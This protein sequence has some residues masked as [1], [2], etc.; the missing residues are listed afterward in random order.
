MLFRSSRP[1]LTGSLLILLLLLAGLVG[2][3]YV[4]LE[5]PDRFRP[6]IAQIIRSASGYEV[7]IDGRLAWRYWPPIAIDA[8]DVS[9]GVPGA[10]PFAVFEGVEMDVDLL[11]LV[12]GRG[13]LEIEQV[14]L[15]GGEILLLIDE[16]GADNWTLPETAVPAPADA[17]GGDEAGPIPIPGRLALNDIAIAYLNRQADQR[18]EVEVESLRIAPLTPDRPFDASVA[19]SFGDPA[20]RMELALESEGRLQFAGDFSAGPSALSFETLSGRLDEAEFKGRATVRF[21][22]PRALSADI[23]IDNL[24]L[25][26]YAGGRE[27]EGAE[28]GGSGQIRRYAAGREEAGETGRP[29][30]PAEVEVIPVSLLKDL[31]LDTVLR[32]D[33]LAAGGNPLTGATIEVKN[34]G[35]RLDLIA[36]ASG[37]EGKLVLKLESEL[38][39][40][41]NSRLT[42]SLD[43]LDLAQ[44]TGTQGIAGALTATSNLRL[45]GGSLGDL[46]DSLIGVTDFSVEGGALDVRPIKRMA[47]A[48]DLLRGEESP[49]S[50]WPDIMPFDRMVGQ[51]RFNRG[52][53]AGQVLNAD[54]E[55]LNIAALGGVDLQS[56]TLHYE[57]T[58]MFTQGK[59]GRFEVSNRLTGIRWP[60]TCRGGLS[61]SLADLCFGRDGAMDELVAEI[62]KQEVK[63]RGSRKLKK[64]LKKQVPE[65]Q[66]D[67]IDEVLDNIFR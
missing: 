41:P 23:G 50:R 2:A 52:M 46:R 40:E 27:E 4:L 14:G 58:A 22:R 45:A 20:N 38:T 7:A 66:G 3:V 55:N 10:E 54:L 21:D 32:I 37:Y 25:S 1:V 18:Y 53:G 30:A 39:G 34:D 57:V 60:L 56:R 9:L 26:R 63:R 35:G 29:D 42:L 65:E 36:G 47:R 8:A 49:V 16:E 13:V 28:Q 17:K 43:G 61:D 59:E 33:R 12:T 6:R 62:A 5:N 51:H 15:S 31:R 67:L 48:V 24:D 11:P 64:F 44:L 19:L